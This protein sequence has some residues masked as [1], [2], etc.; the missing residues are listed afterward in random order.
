MKCK[1][2]T[3]CSL[4]LGESCRGCGYAVLYAPHTWYSPARCA[5]VIRTS[6]STV[7]SPA[8]IEWSPAIFS[9]GRLPAEPSS[10]RGRVRGSS[11]TAESTI[12]GVPPEVDDSPQPHTM[13]E[14]EFRSSEPD[15]DVSQH[16]EDKSSSE[17][18]FSSDD[19][20]EVR[21]M[22]QW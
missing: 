20:E 9:D 1:Q 10:L 15:I 12:D 2:D 14:Q 16:G 7:S 3:F 11:R 17:G 5:C 22:C 19:D 4:L 21:K 18:C 6:K 13:E 8:H